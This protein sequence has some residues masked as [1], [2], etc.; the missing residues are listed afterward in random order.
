VICPAHAP[1]ATR[2][3]APAASHLERLVYLLI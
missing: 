3:A 2:D 1:A